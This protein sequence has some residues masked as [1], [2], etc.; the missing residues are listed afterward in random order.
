MDDLNYVD[1]LDR[2]ARIARSRVA[3]IDEGL[4]ITYA[5]LAD[6]TNRLAHALI[7]AG[8]GPSTRFAA[9][10]P[11]TAGALLALIGAMRA[12]AAWCNIN[13]RNAPAVNIDILRRGGCEVLFFH[14]SAAKLV[15]EIQS[16][17]PT[18]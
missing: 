10:S 9:L 11:N 14:K 4:S 15:P 2:A 3:L 7:A 1:L 18:L 13:F 5:E 17:V 16:G 12:G 6:Q 8:V